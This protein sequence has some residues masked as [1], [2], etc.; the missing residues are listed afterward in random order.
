MP[1]FR[2]L[3]VVPARQINLETQSQ[4]Q[5]GP[6]YIRFGIGIPYRPFQGNITAY[7]MGIAC[8]YTKQ[9]GEILI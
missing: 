1:F 2:D 5:T 3:A 8:F 6:Y 4:T 7:K 9:K